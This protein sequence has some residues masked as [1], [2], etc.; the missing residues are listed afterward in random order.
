M[1]EL[2]SIGQNIPRGDGYDKVTGKLRY[3]VDLKLPGMLHGKLLRS[4]H[5]HARIVSI[6]TTRAQKHPGVKAVVTGKDAPAEKFGFLARERSVFPLDEVRFAGEAVA[7]VA[8]ETPE[9]A[10][11]ALALIKVDYEEL[12]AIFDMEEAMKPNPPVTV[13]PDFPKYKRLPF[14]VQF[15]DLPGRPN[16]YAYRPIVSGD[17]EKGFAEADLVI[18]NRFETPRMHHGALEYLNAM[19]AFEPD[20]S[21]SV[22][23]SLSMPFSVKAALGILFDLPP[24]KIKIYIPL[25]GGCFGAR[26]E[27]TQVAQAALMARKAGRPV[28]LDL[29][30][31][32]FF[33]DGGTR[34]PMVVYIKDGVKKDGTLVARHIKMILHA[35]AYCGIMNVTAR[36]CTFAAGAGYRVPNLKIESFAVASNDPPSV[37]LRGFGAGQVTLAVET[38]MDML[39]EKL[40]MDAAEIRRK[41]FLK[42]G[43]VDGNGMTVHSI[44]VADCL[45]KVTERIDW[46]NKPVREQGPWRIGKG[47]AISNRMVTGGTNSVALAKVHEDATIEIHHT[48]LDQG[49]GCNTVMRQIAAEEF[50]IPVD[51]VSLAPAGSP[52]TCFDHG[53]VGSRST[54]NTGN[55]V[56]LACR[57]A[58]RQLFEAASGRLGVPA[59]ALETKGGAVYIKGASERAVKISELF[60]P[61]GFALKG[62]ELVGRGLFAAPMSFDDPQTGQ[63]KR[64]V[65]GYSYGATAIEAAVNIETGEVKVLRLVD[66]FDVGKAVHPKLSEGQIEGGRAMSLGS[67]L[68]EEVIE[69]RGRMLTTSFMDYKMS[70]AADLP[71]TERT[72]SMLVTTHPHDDGPYGAKGFGEGT[73]L[74]QLPALANAI[75]NAVGIRLK[76]IPFSKE[77]VLAAIKKQ[78]V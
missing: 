36:S 43:E 1:V 5:A 61:L 35:G 31:E 28:R 29:S 54:M 72:E 56:R 39:A 37:A 16:V 25:S 68:S 78:A 12:P 41:N 11:E 51:R 6:D 26:A 69:D 57:D 70:T 20:G 59:E 65:M 74:P 67:A 19:A 42:E 38:Q 73:M 24:S 40:E 53:T 52:V 46:K 75:H 4:P 58:K 8:A 27:A 45:D 44:G 55:A 66:C 9:A 21:L 10:E 71:S 34:E 30:R 2:T 60:T 33:L 77:K 23:T 7:G 13:H 76:E 63:S 49:Q 64:P 15:Q 18:E 3:S 32:E 14:R 17:P 48:A 62:G 47:I 22:W 50:G